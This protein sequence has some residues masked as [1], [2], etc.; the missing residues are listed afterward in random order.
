MSTTGRERG[1]TLLEVMVTSAVLGI[2]V[3]TG[4]GALRST[5]VAT[6]EYLTVAAQQERARAALAMLLAELRQSGR[7]DPDRDDD[8]N[9]ALAVS[10]PDDDPKSPDPY[11]TV[12]FRRVIGHEPDGSPQWGP[13]I[14]FF[15]ELEPGEG[16]RR[17]GDDDDGDGLVDEL[18][19]RRLDSATGELVTVLTGIRRLVFALAEGGSRLDVTLEVYVIGADGSVDALSASSSVR[20]RNR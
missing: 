19:L 18:R 17:D 8:S 4:I 2:L 7:N 16:T 15:A 13:P 5:L 3:L 20:L 9:L 14:T 6:E 12:G 1:V 10:T 11:D